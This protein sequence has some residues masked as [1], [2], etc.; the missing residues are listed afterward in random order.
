MSFVYGMKEIIKSQ[1]G[2]ALFLV[3][4][5]LVLLTAIVGEFCYVMRTEVNIVRNFK[6]MTQSYYIAQ[7]GLNR[8]LFELI[9]SETA[10]FKAESG[11]EKGKEYDEDKIEW[12]INADIPA[13]AFAGGEF[14]VMI[15]NESGKVNINKA[16]KKLLKIM[17]SRF[18]LE[19]LEKDV[20]VDSI[21]DWRDKDRLH[22]L[23][24]AE[25]DYYLSLSEPYEC[26]DDYFD[27]IEELLLVK[28]VTPAIFF[29]GLK[30]MVTVCQDKE[31]TDQK[32]GQK[33]GQNK[34]SAK[35]KEFDY[36]RIN[37]NAAPY[38][39]LMSLPQ[40]TDELAGGIIDYR[41]DQDFNSLNDL[42]SVI[43]FDVYSAVLPYISLKTGPYFSIR[44][45]GKVEGSRTNQG[46]RVMLEIDP[47][48]GKKY[49]IIEWV[50]GG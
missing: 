49:R 34:N 1:N 3:L 36:N 31:T 38:D 15:G 18:E 27:S 5:V 13:I 17:L 26:K 30:D 8:A 25:D 4:W 22:H 37:I 39:I 40:M 44:S 29:A 32:R 10:G 47:K 43:G 28:G 33:K 14:E 2:I 7:A 19:D 24:G 48:Q 16:D 35:T 23:N 6:E 41:K 46:I 20:I 9:K 12:R 42:I 50:E 45:T 21:M 11:N